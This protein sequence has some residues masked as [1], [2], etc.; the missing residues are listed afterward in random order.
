MLTNAVPIH[1]NEM[2]VI[3]AI[4]EGGEGTRHQSAQT[5]SITRYIKLFLN[6][7]SF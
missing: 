6:E 4:G 7:N 3:R 2:F 5:H 1:A